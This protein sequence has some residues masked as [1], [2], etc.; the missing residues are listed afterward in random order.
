MASP[1]AADRTAHQIHRPQARNLG[2]SPRLARKQVKEDMCQALNAGW[3]I[4]RAESLAAAAVDAFTAEI[5]NLPHDAHE[6]L[7]AEEFLDSLRI[8]CESVSKTAAAN[9]LRAAT[10][11]DAL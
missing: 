10:P 1:L 9:R 4:G 2:T 5:D 8:R 6:H 11:R 7:R 3:V